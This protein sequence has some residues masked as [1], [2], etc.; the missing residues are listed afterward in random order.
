MPFTDRAEAGRRLAKALAYLE[1]QDPLIVSLST[2]GVPVAYPIAHALAGELDV[3]DVYRVHAPG[4]PE[5]PVGAVGPGGVRLLD[6]SLLEAQDLSGPALE[7]LVDQAL[8]RVEARSRWLRTETSAIEVRGRTVVLVSDGITD[9]LATRLAA[10]ALRLKGPRRLVIATPVGP[11]DV[12]AD[13]RVEGDAIAALVTV[14]EAGDV[15]DVYLELPEVP[16][17]EAIALLKRHRQGTPPEAPPPMA[18][19]PIRVDPPVSKEPLTA[20]EG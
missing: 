5:H 7:Q 12:L 19:P 16:K 20:S 8:A 10:R 13:L 15:Q 14:A 9:G 4:R 2:E 1:A 11:T 17:H 18:P 3:I 6:P